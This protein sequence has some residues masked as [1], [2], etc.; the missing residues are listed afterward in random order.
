M[1]F[2]SILTCCCV[3]FLSALPASDNDAAGETWG[4]LGVVVTPLPPPRAEAIGL[5]PGVGLRVEEVAA[6]GPAAGSGLASGDVLHRLEDQLLVHP[7]QLVTLVRH[8]IL[9][10][11]VTLTWRRDGT[12]HEAEV[13]LGQRPALAGRGPHTPREPGRGAVPDLPPGVQFHFH[14]LDD[15]TRRRIQEM[16]HG[17]GHPGW[18]GQGFAFPDLERRMEDLRRDLDRLRPDDPRGAPR[19]HHERHMRVHDG[20]YT[21]EIHSVDGETTATVTDANGEVLFEGP[22]D[23]PA[24]EEL[25]E[26]ARDLLEKL[27]ADPEPELVPRDPEKAEEDPR[28]I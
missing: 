8:R 26:R 23:S 9:D 24:I 4:H 22:T 15:E 25:P 14:G 16:L 12:D 27:G 5:K 7:A 28:T 2:T 10:D 6:D 20:D 18:G 17:F 13:E 11:P 19:A 1:R 21:V 3:L